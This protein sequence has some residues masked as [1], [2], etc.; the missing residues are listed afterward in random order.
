MSIGQPVVDVVFCA[1][2]DPT[3]LT[4]L[5]AALVTLSEG[6]FT[7]RTVTTAA[8]SPTLHPL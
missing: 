7:V 5:G 3:T 6:A 4:E 1:S 2:S 8:E